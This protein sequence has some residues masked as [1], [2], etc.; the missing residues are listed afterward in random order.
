M[1]I[2]LIT[3][4]WDSLDIDTYKSMTD[5]L[6]CV[7]GF[8]CILHKFKG[9]DYLHHPLYKDRLTSTDNVEQFTT[10]KETYVLLENKHFIPQLL[11]QGYSLNPETTITAFMRLED[12]ISP[13]DIITL[14]YKHEAQRYN[15][16]INMATIWKNICYNMV[17]SVYLKD[18]MNGVA[19]ND[20]PALPHSKSDG[21]LTDDY[22]WR[23]NKS[24]KRI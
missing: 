4:L 15:F 20:P 3:E 21:V 24:K 1:S 2:N 9:Q 16:Q 10:Q 22:D 6:I 13:E 8:P 18:N 12:D 23:K 11:G 5:E 17:L 7:Y 19:F 14:Q